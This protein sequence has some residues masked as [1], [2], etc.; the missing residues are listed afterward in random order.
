LNGDSEQNRAYSKKRWNRCKES[1]HKKNCR[2]DYQIREK[3]CDVCNESCIQ[4]R[5]LA[6]VV[7]P[8]GLELDQALV[9][10][11]EFGNYQFL[12]PSK[13]FSDAKEELIEKTTVEFDAIL[14]GNLMLAEGY[15][16]LEVFK[17][18]KDKVRYSHNYIMTKE[19]FKDLEKE[20]KLNIK[21]F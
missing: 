21:R 11:W 14:E 8:N 17:K 19:I 16:P 20:K 15:T 9:G 7:D 10:P 18:N 6:R 2:C 3:I 1:K 4:K 13:E 12:L 5:T